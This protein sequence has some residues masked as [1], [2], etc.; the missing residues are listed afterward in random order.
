M[1]A[2][3]IRGLFHRVRRHTVLNSLVRRSLQGGNR[4]LRAFQ[5]R[6]PA[7]GTLKLKEGN[8][9]IRVYTE[10]DDPIASQFAYGEGF[11]EGVILRLEE[12]FGARA[13]T[14]ADIGAN[15][16][17]HSLFLAARYPHLRIISFEP[18]GPNFNRLRRNIALNGATGIEARP[19]ALGD[20]C[21][22]LNFFVPS[23][24]RISDTSSAVPG[25]GAHIYP[26]GVEWISTQVEQQTLD[27]ALEGETIDLIKCDVESFE[28][29]VLKGGAAFFE[30]QKPPIIVEIL[31]T[32]GKAAFFNDFAAR[33]GY[34]IYYVIEGG[35]VRLDA[36]YPPGK[37]M[38]NYLFSTFRYPHAFVPVSHLYGFAGG[39]VGQTA[40]ISLNR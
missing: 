3:T 29:E 26:K 8:A 16:G 14:V 33:N 5:A 31:F 32:E 17:I 28:V 23:D 19:I 18:Y 9:T 4:L 27:V 15:T 21:G 12:A 25:F 7:A 13:R 36:I 39:E 20:K 22:S 38:G 37:G 35:L 10:G 40:E 6:W 34:T 11:E 2:N 24:G 1:I 30:K